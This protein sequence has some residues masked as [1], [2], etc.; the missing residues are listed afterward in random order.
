MHREIERIRAAGAEL[1]VVG[2]GTP[3]WVAG[4]RELT[5]YTGPLYCDP[6]LAAYQAARLK[7]GVWRTV[8]SPRTTLA[9]IRAMRAGFSQ[10]SVMG[11]AF[12]QGGTLVITPPGQ[13][14]YWFVAE[15]AGDRAPL[16]AIFAALEGIART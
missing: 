5:G 16:D 13:V 6:E 14:V 4:F 1:V 8:A 9:A 11:D 12:Q 15:V 7:R 2:A 3:H 10:G